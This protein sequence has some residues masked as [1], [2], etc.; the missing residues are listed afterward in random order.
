MASKGGAAYEVEAGSESVLDWQTGQ[1]NADD[2]S[3]GR[4]KSLS[5]HPMAECAVECDRIRTAGR[6]RALL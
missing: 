3:V 6:L 1:R 4:R 5:G 2:S